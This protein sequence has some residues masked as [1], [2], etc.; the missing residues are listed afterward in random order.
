[1]Q[2]SKKINE[3]QRTPGKPFWQLR[4]YDRI[5]RNEAELN[6]IREYILNNPL[7]WRDDQNNF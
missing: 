7:A 6:R 1:M 2:T 5:I 3:Y 4:F